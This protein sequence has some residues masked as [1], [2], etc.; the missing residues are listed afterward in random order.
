MG[1]GGSTNGG[2]SITEGPSL[3]W[4]FIKVATVITASIYGGNFLFNKVEMA[5]K[6]N[7]KPKTEK[8]VPLKT[9]SI[10]YDGLKLK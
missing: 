6:N 3:L 4:D 7:I 1:A 9:D 2:S 5:K 10:K 8:V